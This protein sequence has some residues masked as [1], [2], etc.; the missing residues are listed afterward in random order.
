MKIS[1]EKITRLYKYAQGYLK[2]NLQY[3]S[4]DEIIKK[5]E[6]ENIIFDTFLARK[7]RNSLE[8][9]SKFTPTGKTE[10]ERQKQL[11]SKT[12]I[13]SL[14]TCQFDLGFFSHQKKKYGKFALCIDILSKRV[15][16]KKISTKEFIVLKQFFHDLFKEPGF[17]WVRRIYSDNEGG[18]SENNISTLEKTFPGKRWILIGKKFENKAFFSERYIRVFKHF[19]ALACVANNIHINKWPSQIEFVL[20]KMNSKKIKGTDFAPQDINKKNFQEFVSQLFKQNPSFEF[21]LYS[22]QIPLIKKSL[23]L[24]FRFE[25]NDEV[26]IRK[27]THIYISRDKEKFENKSVQGHFDKNFVYIIIEKQLRTGNKF[28][29]PVYKVKQKDNNKVIDRFFRENDIRLFKFEQ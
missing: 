14:G 6:K 26:L 13:T 24:L 25:I 27:S 23:K 21:A 5:A 1:E 15:F 19:C 17:T 20:N 4:L 22:I 8:G 7:F 11:F 3:P 18:L 9:I 2:R 10:G 12:K 29:F 16:V 28:I